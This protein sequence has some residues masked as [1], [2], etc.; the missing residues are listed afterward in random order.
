VNFDFSEE[1]ELLRQTAA[2]FL[3]EHA[4]LS[5]ARAA[6]EPGAA[7]SRELWTKV[8]EMGWQG[9]AIPESYG[10]AGFGR[11][12]L[13]V[14]AE[15]LGRTL[16]PL[17][18]SSSVY[19]ATEALL[20]A[21]NESQKQRYLPR[22]AS[23]EIVATFAM[24]EAPGGPGSTGVSAS[25]AD[26]RLTGQKFPVPHGEVADLAVVVA[27]VDPEAVSLVLVELD[28]AGVKRAPVASIDPAF[29]QV[30]LDFEGASAEL[31]GDAAAG[32]LTVQRVIDRGAALLA[33]E[34]LGGARRC[35]SMA[36]DHA[37]ARYQF[38]RPIGSFQAIKHRLADMYALIDLAVSHCY[39]G[40]WAVETNAP[41]LPLAAC[42]ARL[43]ATRAYEY[44]ARENVQ[45]HG[46]IGFTWEADPHLFYRRAKSQAL[47]L[48]GPRHWEDRL[49]D[50]LEAPAA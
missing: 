11:L 15:E 42:G 37:A 23:G 5:C 8:A 36:R 49:I 26:G 20:L 38:G 24:H 47:C 13:S 46:G 50:L 19:F 10:G 3:N 18:F 12:E 39:Y 43:A 34:Q 27:R 28:G 4:P 17:P 9:T 7:H 16:A 31:L 1:Q 22:L 21:G 45:V 14:L 2:D 25:W 6:L 30:V 48:G 29:P 35:L 44:C 32:S 33:F 40:A 41:E